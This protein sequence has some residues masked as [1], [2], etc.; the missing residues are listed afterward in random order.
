MFL[1][2]LSVILQT[3]QIT[4]SKNDVYNKIQ[5]EYHATHKQNDD[6]I[7]QYKER[8]KQLQYYVDLV[9]SKQEACDSLQVTTINNDKIN[10]S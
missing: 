8:Q 10:L 1:L 9:K 3:N 7:Y 4:C 2:F 5:S 6:Y